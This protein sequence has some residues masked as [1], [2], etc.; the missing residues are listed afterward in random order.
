ML[1]NFPNRQ[2]IDIKLA[3]V[4]EVDHPGHLL[5]ECYPS[6]EMQSE[7]STAPDDWANYVNSR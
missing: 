1:K 5:G 6:A 2:W 4:V 3:T 7:Y